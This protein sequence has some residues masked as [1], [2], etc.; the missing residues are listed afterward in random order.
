[1]KMSKERHIAPV[2]LE[3]D[4]SHGKYTADQKPTKMPNSAIEMHFTFTQGLPEAC[5][6]MLTTGYIGKYVQKRG[7]NGIINMEYQSVDIQAN[8]L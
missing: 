3:L 2:V 5:V 4:P 8:L 6:L 7:T 1:M